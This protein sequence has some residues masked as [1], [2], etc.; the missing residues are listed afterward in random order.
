MKFN[1]FF[2]ELQFGKNENSYF[3]NF[4]YSPADEEERQFGELFMTVEILNNPGGAEA[5]AAEMFARLQDVYYAHLGDDSYSS[6]ETALREVNGALTDMLER[7]PQKWLGRINAVTA[8]RSE[9]DLHLSQTGVAEAYLLRAGKLV[10]ISENSGEQ[11]E[12]AKENQGKV[13]TFVNIS[14][15]E[16]ANNDQLIFATERLLKVISQDAIE[17]IFNRDK[18]MNFLATLQEKIVLGEDQSLSLAFVSVLRDE[19]EEELA[20]SQVYSE[21]DD[22]ENAAYANESSGAT[23]RLSRTAGAGKKFMFWLK[24]DLPAGIGKLKNVKETLSDWS[25][26]IRRNTDKKTAT[27]ALVV[28]I[29]VL[30]VAVAVIFSKKSE[31]RDIEVFQ[32]S[33]SELKDQMAKAE[34]LLI[35]DSA[36]ATK[37]LLGEDQEVDRVLSKGIFQANVEAAKK[38][39]RLDLDKVQGIERID[40]ANSEIADVAS[41]KTGAKPLGIV[42]IDNSVHAYD[43]DNW[44]SITLDKVSVQTILA[45]SKIKTGTY[46]ADQGVTVFLTEDGRLIEWSGTQA[47]LAKTEDETFHQAKAI[48]QYARY[49]YFL[50]TDN[51]QIWKYSR[52]TDGYSQAVSYSKNANLTQGTDLVIDG[53]IYVTSLDGSIIRIF[54]GEKDDWLPQIP[55]GVQ[56]GQPRQIRTSLEGKS[57][58]VLDQN[59]RIIKFQKKDG[60]Y[61]GQYVFETNGGKISDFIV[62]DENMK[63]FALVGSKIYMTP[64]VR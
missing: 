22:D 37:I 60:A 64:I 1:T 51:N 63:I 54:R 39:I 3:K 18:G 5:V 19:K 42:R 57:V 2:S 45:G 41:V 52:G 31:Q 50:D 15:G 49:L 12:D 30:V 4:Q 46:F 23:V 56:I 6:F 13:N 34:R 44:Y 43:Q 21:K 27:F 38:Q 59:A 55:D 28:M 20:K 32:K 10:R 40:L 61:L 11:G 36:G 9:Q 33:F 48:G 8:I 62:D 35:Y 24:N 58:Y 17:R 47:E 53:N 16:V 26:S 29:V 7:S 25:D 14:S